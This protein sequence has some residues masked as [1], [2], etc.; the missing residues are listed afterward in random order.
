MTTF[1]IT[2]PIYYVNDRPHIGHVYTTTLA[3]AVARYRRL[4]GEDV[5]FLTGTDEHAA[6]VVDAARE[7]GLTPQDWAD[8]NAKEFQ[9]TFVRLGFTN[10]DFIRTTEQRHIQRVEGYVKRLLDSGDVYL[11]DYEGWYDAGQEEY[12]PDNKAKEQDYKSAINGKPLVTKSEK[13][14]FFRLTSFAEELVGRIERDEF[15]ILP[16]AR[17]N[18]I[19]NRLRDPELRDVALSRTGSGDWGIKVP[20]DAEHT[21][22]VWIDA[23]LNYLTTV[24]T[25]ERRKYWP[26]DVQFIGKDILWFH[27]AI[28]PAL[29]LALGKLEPWVELPRVLYA[30]SFWTSEGQKMSKSLGNFIDLERLDSYVAE[31]G[32]DAVRWFLLTQG[33]LAANDS[34]FSHDRFGEV[35]NADLANTVGNCFSRV[36]TMTNKYFGGKLPAAGPAID[37]AD[38]LRQATADAVV[39]VQTAYA[40]LRLSDAAQAAL[41]LVRA[42]DGFIEKTQPFKL[43]KDEAKLPLVGTVLVTCAEALRV[44]S[45]LLWPALPTKIEALWELLGCAHYAQALADRGQGQLAAWTAWGL[46]PEG[47]PVQQAKGLFPRWQAPKAKKPPQPKAEKPKQAPKPKAPPPGPKDEVSYEEFAALDIRIARVKTA[48]P[49]E[50]ADKLLHLTLVLADGEERTVLSGIRA[51]Y[52]PETLVGK[53]VVY[54][55]NLKPRKIRGVMSQGMVLAGN[56]ADGGAA[57][58][59]ADQELPDGAKVS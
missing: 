40:E 45:L 13:N 5:F 44:A 53:Q 26:A 46:L 49:L 18:E 51:W 43:A 17:R 9:D 32:L 30:H 48:A 24:D 42:I 41:G 58:L 37:G 25:D 20:G 19:L 47:T 33:P 27:A 31:F 52:E 10:D 11:G 4:L 16:Q 1:Y 8:K 29:L 15:Q 50:G 36:A 3:D 6:K 23:L 59:H 39:A 21:I 14:Y 56:T 12:V 34:D 54:L 38:E 28:W 7:R 57:L 22:Y 55:A 35:Y 2:T